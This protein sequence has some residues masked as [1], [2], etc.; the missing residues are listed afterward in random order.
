[1]GAFKE[2]AFREADLGSKLILAVVHRR[3]FEF[4][5]TAFL[6]YILEVN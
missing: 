6:M 2:G 3:R 1:L 4:L 5:E